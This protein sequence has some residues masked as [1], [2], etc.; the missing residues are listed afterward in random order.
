MPEVVLIPQQLMTC[1]RDAQTHIFTL[2]IRTNEQ[3]GHTEPVEVL[4][5]NK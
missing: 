4:G 2:Y 3:V 1:E 5:W